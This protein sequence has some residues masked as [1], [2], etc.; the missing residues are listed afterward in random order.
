MKCLDAIYL[1]SVGSTLIG[2]LAGIILYKVFTE[3]RTKVPPYLQK[4]TD[5]K[6]K[7]S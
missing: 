5:K 3:E 6:E 7:K 2:A 1:A 4:K